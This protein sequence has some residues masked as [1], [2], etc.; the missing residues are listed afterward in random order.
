[1]RLRGRDSLKFIFLF[2]NSL[3]LPKVYHHF[4]AKTTADDVSP[5]HIEDVKGKMC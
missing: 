3:C 1:M 4:N 5:Y 2:G